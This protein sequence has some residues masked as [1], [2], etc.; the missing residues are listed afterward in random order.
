[1]LVEHFTAAPRIAI[2]DVASLHGLMGVMVVVTVEEV[3][4]LI[5]LL[6]PSTMVEIMAMEALLVGVGCRRFSE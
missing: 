5:V 2:K 1:M 3:V 6:L 4:V